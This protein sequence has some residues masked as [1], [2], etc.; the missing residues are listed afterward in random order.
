M[1]SEFGYF[2]N[3]PPYIPP[4]YLN[5]AEPSEAGDIFQVGSFLYFIFTEEHPFGSSINDEAMLKLKSSNLGEFLNFRNVPP[6][7]SRIIE[8]C[9]SKNQKIGTAQP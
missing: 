3:V 5:G 9:L 6:E 2:S 8:K 1:I 7:I 4:E